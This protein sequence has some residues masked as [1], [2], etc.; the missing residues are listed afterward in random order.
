MTH[1][2][3][4]RSVAAY[5]DEY[6]GTSLDTEGVRRRMLLRAGTRRRRRLVA[7]RL[8]LPMAATFFGSVALAASHGS[9]PRFD[10]VRRWFGVEAVENPSAV[11]PER[12][13]SPPRAPL[14][15]PPATTPPVVNEPGE[16]VRLPELLPAPERLAPPTRSRA[17]P[18]VASEKRSA[19]L[20]SASPPADAPSGTPDT[21][22][23]LLTEDLAI[24][25]RAHQLHFHGGDPAAALR[26]WDAYLVAYPA[27]TFAPEARFNRA[28]C[29]LRMGRRAEAK[30]I[31]EPIAESS[32]AYGRERARALL[33][34]ME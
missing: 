5:R 14:A 31:L 4:E 7:L 18:R 17:M 33:A 22:P 29:L 30:G 15:P 12:L 26:A 13:P 25:Q 6:P 2:L 9:L 21:R 32:F 10:D 23:N 19:P 24:Y 16:I 1:D 27:G 8:V 28:V 11:L 34:A 20:A 3:L